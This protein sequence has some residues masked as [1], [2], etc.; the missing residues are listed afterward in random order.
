MSVFSTSQVD[1][2][3]PGR[4]VPPFS[5]GI[6][7]YKNYDAPGCPNY[8]DTAVNW[9]DGNQPPGKYAQDVFLPEKFPTQSTR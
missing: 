6:W 1:P 9:G 5:G 3:N 4:Y 2:A 7:Q 8:S